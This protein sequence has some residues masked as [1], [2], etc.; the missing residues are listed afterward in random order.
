[1]KYNLLIKGVL[2]LAFAIGMNYCINEKNE[3]KVETGT[4]SAPIK[5]PFSKNVGICFS[6]EETNW[7]I[8]PTIRYNASLKN[9]YTYQRLQSISKDFKLIRIYS[10]LVAGFESTGNL[11]PEGYAIT[12]LAK[13]DSGTEFML[14][15]SNALS[16]YI[17]PSN[18]QLF[19]DTMNYKFGSSVSQVKTILVGNEIN[20]INNV[21]PNQIS[22]I[23]KNFKVALAKRNLNIPVSVSF[24]NLPIQ[25]GDSFSDKLVASVV[26]S[27][28]TTW[29]SNKPF[30]FID[31][32]PDSDGI[33]NA[34]GVYAWQYGV[35]EYYKTIYP[36]L[37]IFIG[38]TGA[39]G[40]GSDSATVVCV[41][42]VV[43]Q[44]IIQ[45]DSIS[46]T[47][48]TFL[49]EAVNEPLKS[50]NPNQQFMGLYLDSSNPIKT[51][52]V[53]KKGINLPLIYRANL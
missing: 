6:V 40:S 9:K 45:Y 22:T 31:P 27:W 4:F 34:K 16:W 42:S 15:T 24:N 52:L 20:C 12:Q 53:L 48:P 50:N 2:F 46:K 29:N 5:S 21:T 17:I 28:D 25:K 33:N 32:Y 41:N 11:S 18:V 1:M 7:F 14:G 19:V 23:I 26:N 39:E 8:S 44:L 43:N 49:F 13:Q 51:N 10:F 47:V 37:Q 35:T 30:V 36:N 3:I 38:E